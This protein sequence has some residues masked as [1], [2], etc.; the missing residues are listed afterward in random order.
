[1][2]LFHALNSLSP[3]L[4][5]KYRLDLFIMLFFSIFFPSN[6]TL[7]ELFKLQLRGDCFNCDYLGF[8]NIIKCINLQKCFAFK[9]EAR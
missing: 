9:R 6:Y 3:C 2:P 4:I 5:V 1:M 8:L 7:F